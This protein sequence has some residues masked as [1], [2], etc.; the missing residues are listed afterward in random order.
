MSIT[1]KSY[2]EYTKEEL[3]EMIKN[4]KMRKKFGY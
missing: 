3:I 1:S 2:D 4:L